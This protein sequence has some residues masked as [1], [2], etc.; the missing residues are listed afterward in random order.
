MFLQIP[1]SLEPR[2]QKKK[3]NRERT[4]VL[5][6]SLHILIEMYTS[7]SSLSRSTVTDVCECGES[8][9]CHRNRKRILTLLHPSVD[10][11]TYWLCNQGPSAREKRLRN[12]VSLLLK[13]EHLVLHQTVKK[14]NGP[15]ERRSGFNLCEA[16][17]QQEGNRE[18]EDEWCRTPVCS[19][20]RRTQVHISSGAEQGGCKTWLQQCIPQLLHTASRLSEQTQS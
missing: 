10:S 19:M 11:G 5:L 9:Q 20:S 12:Y 16:R 4:C 14:K 17:E 1:T 3:D 8:V 15:R 7:G 13:L 2:L 18:C 6:I